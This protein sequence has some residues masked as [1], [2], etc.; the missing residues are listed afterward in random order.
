MLDS[1]LVREQNGPF[2]HQ[3][4]I[5]LWPANLLMLVRGGRSKRGEERVRT[6]TLRTTKSWLREVKKSSPREQR[7]CSLSLLSETKERGASSQRGSDGLKSLQRGGQLPVLPLAAG[8]KAF[9]VEKGPKASGSLRSP[10]NHLGGVIRSSIW[11]KLPESISWI[12]V[13]PKIEANNLNTCVKTIL[14]FKH[15]AGWYNVVFLAY[16]R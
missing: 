12:K 6:T 7:S 14:L 3:N 9:L 16:L 5:C 1:P 10:R 11:L 4:L 2:G 8:L 13:I 15:T